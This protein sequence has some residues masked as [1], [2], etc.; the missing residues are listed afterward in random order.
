MVNLDKSSVREKLDE[1][2]STF[3]EIKK[4]KEINKRKYY[5]F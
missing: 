2:K 4:I 5:A 1:I 3:N